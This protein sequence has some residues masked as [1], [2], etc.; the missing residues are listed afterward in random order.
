MVASCCRFER[1]GLGMLMMVAVAVLPFIAVKIVM[2][3]E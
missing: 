3:N 1:R 2:N